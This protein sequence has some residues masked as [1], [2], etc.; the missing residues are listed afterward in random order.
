LKPKEKI[1]DT[2]HILNKYGHTVVKPTPH[3]CN[4]NPTELA[5]DKI[6]INVRNLA[7]ALNNESQN[8]RQN[9]MPQRHVQWRI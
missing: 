7:S 8:S 1:Y 6:K 3:M 9:C 4:L 2:E 5:C